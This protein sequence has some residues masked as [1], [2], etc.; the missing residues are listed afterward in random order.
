MQFISALYL[1]YRRYGLWAYLLGTALAL[2]GLYHLDSAWGIILILVGAL[3]ALSDLA[4]FWIDR[5]LPEAGRHRR[6]MAVVWALL[7]LSLAAGLVRYFLDI[8]VDKS[9]R[10]EVAWSERL[11]TAL[12]FLSILSYFASAAYRF[13]IGLSQAMKEV[14]DTAVRRQKQ[15]YFQFAALSI[16][17]VVLSVVALNYL[18]VLRNPSIDLSPGYLSFGKEARRVIASLERE[19]DAYI[20]IPQ[21]QA[22]RLRGGRIAT[23][24]LYRLAQGVRVMAEQLPLINSGIKVHFLNADLEDYDTDE[25]GKVRNGTIIFR[26]IK[27]QVR[28][29]AERPYNEKRIYIHTERDRN[30]LEREM[31][32]ALVDLA[33]PAKTVYYT[34][35][36]GER[37]A[38]GQEESR[39]GGFKSYKEQLDLYNA[40]FRA[41]DEGYEGKVAIPE[42]ADILFISGPTVPFG[43]EARQEI[44]SYLA[45][46]GNLFVMADPAGEESFGWLFKELGGKPYRYSNTLLT[47]TNFSGV[48]LTNSFASKH[49]AT[50]NVRKQ[51]RPFLVLSQNGSIQNAPPEALEPADAAKA[52]GASESADA[53]TDEAKAADGADNAAN[54]VAN[55]DM[56]TPAAP[57]VDQEVADGGNTVDSGDAAAGSDTTVGGAT[58]VSGDDSSDGKAEKD[59]YDLKELRPKPILH[60]MNNSYEDLNSNSRLD[61]GEEAGRHLLGL[62]YETAN[63]AEGPR[64]VFMSGVNWL[65]ERGLAFPV[66][67]KNIIF[68][69]DLFLW[70][71]ANPVVASIEIEDRPSRNVRITDELK[72]KLLL[73]GI[74]IFPLAVGGGL[75]VAILI[76]RRRKR[77]QETA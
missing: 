45:G 41:L 61:Q 13:M 1:H 66:D 35:N 64:L 37:L 30:R 65:S 29:I 5:S 72:W 33:S 53:A 24:R 51:S 54:A 60:S 63:A 11:R 7:L 57:S 12:L 8:P 34:S 62:T 70:I 28:N 49:P 10:V 19:V 44:L 16:L 14:S 38:L 40:R 46:G 55:A 15:S 47:N 17:A 52:V 32:R 36:N 42:D 26:V 6:S 25:F 75:A 77:F 58:V 23:P 3:I 59:R 67:H 9:G 73:F 39:S 20:F 50:E 27:Q 69:T 21:Q 74:V 4:V 56:A 48:M 2:F 31:T 22:V 76:Y 71:T 18:T 43:E 68:A